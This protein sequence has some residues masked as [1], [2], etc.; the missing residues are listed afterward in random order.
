MKKLAVSL[1]CSLFCFL[2]VLLSTKCFA[3][4]RPVKVKYSDGTISVPQG[5]GGHIYFDDETQCTV[6]WDGNA[7]TQ[8]RYDSIK[9]IESAVYQQKG[10]LMDDQP[11]NF[12]TVVYEDDQHHDQIVLFRLLENLWHRETTDSLFTLLKTRSGKTI[13]LKYATTSDLHSTLQKSLTGISR[14]IL[15]W[16][17]TTPKT[18]GHS[19]SIVSTIDTDSLTITSDAREKTLTIPYGSIASIEYSQRVGSRAWTAIMWSVVTLNEGPLLFMKKLR[20]HFLTIEYVDPE[21]QTQY[22]VIAVP[23]FHSR[24]LIAELEIRTGKAVS[25]D[26]PDILNFVYG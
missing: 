19:E 21:G 9:F 24:T 10:T 3:E 17:G 13:N 25:F 15:V 8:F 11:L 14:K 1:C 18:S 7:V 5:T 26:P 6:R 2:V 16:S 23:K 22:I 4:F 12:L 20:T